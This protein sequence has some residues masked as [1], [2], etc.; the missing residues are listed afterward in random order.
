MTTDGGE[1]AGWNPLSRDHAQAST[2]GNTL[3]PLAS[4]PLEGRPSPATELA[5]HRGIAGRPP[6]GSHSSDG[7]GLSLH[8]TS[9]LYQWSGPLQHHSPH[10]ISDRV[11]LRP[12]GSEPTAGRHQH[13]NVTG[14]MRMQVCSSGYELPRGPYLVGSPSSESSDSRHDAMAR[15]PTLPLS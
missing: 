9:G 14:S 11:P 10:S 15:G 4:W 8:S 3:T 7:R 6:L 13:R 1:E 2:G 12:R 5:A